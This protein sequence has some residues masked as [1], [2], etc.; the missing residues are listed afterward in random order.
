MFAYI[1]KKVKQMITEASANS[2]PPEERKRLLINGVAIVLAMVFVE[3]PI[4]LI[5]LYISM[6]LLSG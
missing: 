2:T 6:R 4:L 3:M 5:L 1:D